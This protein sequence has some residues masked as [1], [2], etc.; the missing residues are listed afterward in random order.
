MYASRISKLGD[1]LSLEWII[2]GLGVYLLIVA[3][4]LIILSGCD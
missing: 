1:K 2:V 4:I 3:S